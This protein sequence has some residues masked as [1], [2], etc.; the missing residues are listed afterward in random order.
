MT[1]RIRSSGSVTTTTYGELVDLQHS[2][3]PIYRQAGA[4]WMFH[5]S[6][7]AAIKKL[8]DSQGRPL[9]NVNIAGPEPDLILGSPYRINNHMAVMAAS[10]KSILYGLMGKYVV[11]RVRD[12]VLLRLVERYADLLQVGFLAFVRSDGNL[13]DAGTAPVKHYA[14][15]AT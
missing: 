12:M 4:E 7:L 10:A 6:T 15:S 14:N 5:D 3:D 11:R 9:W 2:V 8:E 13:V 1:S